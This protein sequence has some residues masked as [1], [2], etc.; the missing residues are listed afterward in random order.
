MKNKNSADLGISILEG[1][2]RLDLPHKELFHEYYQLSVRADLS[3]VEEDRIDEILTTA[4]NDTNFAK[5]LSKVDQLV[6]RQLGTETSQE[7]WKTQIDKAIKLINIELYE[8]D[9]SR[10]EKKDTQLDSLSIPTPKNIELTENELSLTKYSPHELASE[11]HSLSVLP[12]LSK[13]EEERLNEILA[14]AENDYSLA[15]LLRKADKSAYK[16]IGTEVS[17]ENCKI[18]LDKAAKLLKKSSEQVDE[19]KVEN[20]RQKF[21]GRMRSIHVEL[22]QFRRP[23][24]MSRQLTGYRQRKRAFSTVM[25][26]SVCCCC[27]CCVM[28]MELG[29]VASPGSISSLVIKILIPSLITMWMPRH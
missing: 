20:P 15:E 14:F 16:K 13:T 27:C 24:G 1:F 10:I 2:S 6:Y 29:G 28:F 5:Y 4:E 3:E 7:D 23:S 18:Q 21:L 25:L 26:L 22:P 9:L 12:H 19:D 17:H 11:Y 8:P